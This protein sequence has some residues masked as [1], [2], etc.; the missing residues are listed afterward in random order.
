[1]H[2]KEI[3]IRNFR[4]LS[5][6]KLELDKEPCLMIGRN[7][8][9]KTSFMVL[10]EKFLKNKGFGFNDFPVGL[11]EK[12][13]NMTMDT[14]VTDLAIRMMLTIEYGADD[15]LDVLSEFIVDLKPRHNEVYLMFEC[16]IDQRSLFAAMPM[17][18][19][20]DRKEF[21]RRYLG[22]HL[23]PEVYTFDDRAI[24]DD[25]AV[26]KQKRA[27]MVKKSLSDVTKLIDFEI[28]H[29]KRSVAS[30]EEHRGSKVLSRL[31]TAYYNEKNAGPEG[32]FNA[33]NKLIRETDQKLDATYQD[34]FGEYLQ[35]AMEFLG[36]RD[37]HVRSNL[38]A[39]EILEG[40]SQVLYG[41]NAVQLPEHQNG[42]GHVNIL[43]LLLSIQIKLD[44]FAE[45]KKHI[46]LL[47]IEEPE[48]HTHPQ[49]QYNFARKIS[50]LVGKVP[51]L[52]TII[53]THSPHI[54]SRYPFENLRYM[55]AVR[56]GGS[57]ANVE[58][59]HFHKTLKEKYGTQEAEFQF[60]KQ[61]LTIAS[62]E[63]FFVDK[64]IFIEG[65]SE[66]LLLPYFISRFDRAKWEALK[67]EGDEEKMKKYVPLAA[68]NIAIVEAGANAKA[69][70]HFVEFLDI[71]TLIITD[72]DTVTQKVVNTGKTKK[73]GTPATRTIYPECK[74]SDPAACNTS[75]A[76]IKYYLEMPD[77]EIL[78]QDHA[79][80]FRDMVDHKLSPGN[81]RIHLSY[82]CAEEPGGFRPRS[83]EDAFVNVN[84]K[85]MAQKCEVIDGLKNRQTLER[86]AAKGPAAYKEINDIYDLTERVLEGKSGLASS[87]LY[88]AY[89]EDVEWET[90][91]YIKEGLEWL[92]NQTH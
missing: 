44:S 21:I 81:P 58:I 87:L 72:I 69:F 66:A 48:A 12:L 80:W 73:D 14:D 53:T 11:R 4:I 92:Y 43:Y 86:Y 47:F 29:A 56:D 71:P 42:L 65:T 90:P 55:A 91:L 37:L 2:I 82:Q 57:V 84:L 15:K 52:Q 39:G 18:E 28:I 76:T 24:F 32:R 5:D 78:S 31:T 3:A 68:Q 45:N 40:S 88:Q 23:K 35:N 13:L 51:D 19:S 63:L 67:Q 16:G 6:S 70:R 74:V 17:D 20:I 62:S 27:Q 22:D 1:M 38:S 49:L 7:N 60:L 34:F 9:G 26:M 54:V 64:A 75:N 50:D 41:E 61:Y 33:I 79:K 83:F 46:R 8:A 10:V 85:K 25:P 89:A 59:K 77:D 36:T 30:S